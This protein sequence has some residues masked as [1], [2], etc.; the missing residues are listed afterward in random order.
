MEVEKIS[1]EDRTVR[2]LGIEEKPENPKSN[3]A[4]VGL[5]FYPSGVSEKADLVRP[6]ARGE[7]EITSLNEIYLREGRLTAQLF[8]RGY[9]W[10]D[11][12]TVD[13]LRRATSFVC[14]IEQYQGT[15]VNRN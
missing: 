13:S 6:S 1:D 9:T 7:L 10:M 8:G 4:V 14:M 11:A 3:Y 15:I 2:V 12:G 5:Y